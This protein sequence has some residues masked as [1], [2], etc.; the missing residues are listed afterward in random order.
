MTMCQKKQE[1]CAALPTVL[2]YT[3]INFENNSRNNNLFESNSSITVEEQAYVGLNSLNI[4][5]I[6]NHE[7]ISTPHEAIELQ[8]GYPELRDNPSCYSN[9]K[10]DD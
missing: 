3:D 1:V 2:G 4:Y 6:Y 9:Q 7:H 10:Y 8:L 5:R